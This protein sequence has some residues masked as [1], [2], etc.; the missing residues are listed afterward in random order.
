[1]VLGADPPTRSPAPA[2]LLA[3]LTSEENAHL[4]GQVVYI[5]GG[6]DAVMR[7]DSTW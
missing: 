1:V 5:D 3:W 2:Y 7:G 4:C 6:S